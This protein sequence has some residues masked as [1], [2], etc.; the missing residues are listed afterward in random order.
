MFKLARMTDY[1][2][3][4]LAEMVENEGI[5]LSASELS[6]RTGLP[7]PTVSKL[8]K[9]LGK[10]VVVEAVRGA[11]GGYRLA[12]PAGDIAVL[13]II[14]AIEGPVA[15]TACVEES[16]DKCLLEGVCAMNGRWNNV[17]RAVVR[18]LQGVSL[19]DMMPRKM[20]G[21]TEGRDVE[22]DRNAA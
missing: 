4:V 6:L 21:K 11:S 22:Q 18:A 17:N 20:N 15:L 8:L 7:E 10:K 19:A 13:D 5:L 16:D 3:I 12:R 1:A 2:V 14:T 9:L